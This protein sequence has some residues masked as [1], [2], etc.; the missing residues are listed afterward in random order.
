MFRHRPCP[1]WPVEGHAPVS[2][3]SSRR[4]LLLAALAAGLAATASLPASAGPA[5]HWHA[6][7]QEEAGD[8]SA[9]AGEHAAG[10]APH[11]V[12]EA[13]AGAPESATPRRR[14]EAHPDP[15]LAAAVAR[16]SRA[17][18][19]ASSCDD[20]AAPRSGTRAMARWC[21]SHSTSTAAP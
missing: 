1:V 18:A 14:A 8:T 2:A 5:A 21:L 17:F 4:L 13:V 7:A 19:T 3:V 11:V 10:L 6:A 20:V 15:A 9:D 16:A 12:E